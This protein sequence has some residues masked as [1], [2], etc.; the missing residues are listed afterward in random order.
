MF[1]KILK[2]PL[3]L[4]SLA[5]QQI[6]NIAFFS[7]GISYK[8][9]F[10]KFIRSILPIRRSELQKFI[11][12]VALFFLFAFVYNILRPLKIT[13]VTSQAAGGEMIPFLKT[14]GILPGAFCFTLL[15]IL[16]V[17]SYLKLAKLK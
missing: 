14:W 3:N 15:F 13:L 12:T 6:G 8:K 17:Q 16:I 4:S 9:S 2:Q 10:K 7:S 11:P 5:L 1:Q